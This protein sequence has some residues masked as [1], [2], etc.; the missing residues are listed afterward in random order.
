MTIDLSQ[1]YQVFFDECKEHLQEME[2]LLLK[3][4][5]ENP[6]FEQLNTIFR[7]AHSIKGGSATFGFNDISA[8]THVLENLLDR[9]RKKE[10]LLQTEMIDVFLQAADVIK[11]QLNCH[12]NGTPADA[13]VADVVTNKLFTFSSN[14]NLVSQRHAR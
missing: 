9:L 3:L 6:N 13:K 8:V 1:F 11:L 14:A 2:Q 10:I 4:D 12:I 7:A 5:V